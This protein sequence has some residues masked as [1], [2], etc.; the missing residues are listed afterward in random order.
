MTRFAPLSI[1]CVLTAVIAS[2]TTLELLNFDA[3]IDKS[4]LVVRGRVE[5]CD[6]G[7]RGAMIYTQC[8]VEVIETLKG[9]PTAQVRFSVPGG[10]AGNLR[11]SIAGA[12]QFQTG[13]EYVL[14]LWTGPSGLTQVMGLSQGKFEI[15]GSGATQ[16]AV[17]EAV[18]DVTMLDGMGHEV[19]DSG[20]RMTLSS[21]RQRMA[22]RLTRS[23]T[24]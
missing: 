19:H 2:A 12:P 15:R 21:L 13:A 20:L 24:R 3:L 17:R 5:N 8:A 11:Q 22:S 16:T 18:S 1:L 7:F 6:G 23:V 14:F 4:T 9:A 10:R